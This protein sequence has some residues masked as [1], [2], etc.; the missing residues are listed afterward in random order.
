MSEGFKGFVRKEEDD[1]FNLNLNVDEVGKIIKEYKRL[2]K[3]QRSGLYQA[4]KLSGKKTKVDKLI[5]KYG[6]DS[7]AIE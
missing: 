3:F 4:A 2:K 1:E 5:E 6:I 7:E